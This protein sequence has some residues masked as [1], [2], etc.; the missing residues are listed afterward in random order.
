MANN[1][2]ASAALVSQTY[3][4]GGGLGALDVH[5]GPIVSYPSET[6]N[7]TSFDPIDSNRYPRK[8]AVGGI[9]GPHHARSEPHSSQPITD[10][11]EYWA[12]Q[13]LG[14]PPFVDEE[15]Y[16]DQVAS[17]AT[18]ITAP[19]C[20]GGAD[21]TASPPGSGYFYHVSSN[22]ANF[23]LP[24]GYSVPASTAIYIYGNASFGQIKIDL[25]KPAFNPNSAFIV[26]GD[27]T[28][29]GPTFG[30]TLTDLHVPPTA[31]LEYPFATSYPC[32]SV[33]TPGSSGT[34]R[35]DQTGLTRSQVDFRGFLFVKGNLVVTTGNWVL[36]GVVRVDGQVIIQNGARLTILYDDE[37][38]HGIHTYPFELQT[39]SLQDAPPS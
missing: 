10:G 22:T 12:Y 25:K 28:L 11:K 34:C 24:T 15:F 5:W 7:L 6:W 13:A 21:C 36:A 30:Q 9:T 20:T 32:S 8:F 18:G 39:D 29:N 35:S 23:D 37:I 2:S 1:I 14:F 4:L 27:L 19:T 26:T 33:V 31:N 16:I 3:T 17:I 38:N